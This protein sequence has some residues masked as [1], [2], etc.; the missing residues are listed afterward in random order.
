MSDWKLIVPESATNLVPN[1]QF[2]YSVATGWTTYATGAA[3]GT[4]ALNGTLQKF[5]PYS[6][7]LS[8]TGGALADHFGQYAGC[9]T[10]TL[11]QT[12]IATAWVYLQTG[13]TAVLQI[14]KVA[15][16]GVLQTDSATTTTTGA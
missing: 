9:G 7:Q 12:Y 2:R 14:Q 6:L 8:K 5:G 13:T 16:M 11:S 3:A 10:S 15:G 1:P 4:R